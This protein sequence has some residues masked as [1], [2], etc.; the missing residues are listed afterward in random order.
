MRSPVKII[1][2]G[3]RPDVSCSPPVN[4]NSHENT[5][6]K[7]QKR[8]KRNRQIK[9]PPNSGYQEN[10]DKNQTTPVRKHVDTKNSNNINVQHKHTASRALSKHFC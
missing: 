3:N 1:Q 6:W 9:N 10:Q 4:K 7:R 2:E 5:E 8:K